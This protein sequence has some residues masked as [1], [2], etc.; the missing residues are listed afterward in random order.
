MKDFFYFSRW[1]RRGILL[2]LVLI[3]AIAGGSEAYLRH[4]NG[5]KADT[6]DGEEGTAA[7]QEY[8]AF[9]ASLR[10]KEQEWIRRTSAYDRI[11]Q[12]PVQLA[13]FD[14][15]TADS[16]ALRRLGLPGW[17]ARNV[18]RYREKG[19]RFRRAEDFKKIYGLTAGQYETLRPYLRIAPEDTARVT[20]QLYL[21]P[22]KTDSTERP[23]KYPTGTVV[24]LNGADTTE[25]KK[26]PG[27][28]SGIARMIAGYRQRLG[29]FYRIEQLKEINLDYEQLRP[30]FSIQEDSIRRINLNRAGIERLRRHPY[31]N[32]YQAKAFVE[33]RRKHGELRNLK[34]F[35]LHEDFTA[36]DLERISHYVCF[37]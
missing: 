5:G 21:P 32:F 35:A 36:D 6:A 11:P 22:V 3:F 19:G 30:W 12:P 25:L 26:I 1:E 34:V 17:M 37:E 13:P 10:Q 2:L 14:P 27:I 29:G 33:Y 28:G 24:D 23:F 15:N 7:R 20:A 18:V 4:R 9:A 16:A 8:A 31:I